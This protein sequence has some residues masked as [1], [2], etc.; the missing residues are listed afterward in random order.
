MLHRLST[1][2]SQPHVQHRI[3]TSLQPRPGQP[4]GDHL[5]T[6]RQISLEAIG[7]VLPAFGLTRETVDVQAR[8]NGILGEHVVSDQISRER[9]VEITRLLQMP[10][11]MFPQM[12]GR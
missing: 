9:F 4:P 1:F 6:V 2:Y 5:A 3:R 8:L 12:M 7:A 10:P 11:R